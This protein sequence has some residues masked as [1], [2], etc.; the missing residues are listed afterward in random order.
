MGREGGREGGRDGGQRLPAGPPWASATLRRS[1]RPRA[2]HVAGARGMR[3]AWPKEGRDGV[4]ARAA[5]RPGQSCKLPSRKQGGGAPRLQRPGRSWGQRESSWVSDSAGW[6]A[7]QAGRLGTGRPR[8][9]QSGGGAAR[10]RMGWEP[11]P[12]AAEGAG[13]RAEPELR[14][15]GASEH[16]RAAPRAR[17]GSAVPG[18]GAGRGAGPRGSARP[19]SGPR[20]RSPAPARLRAALR[21]DWLSP[22]WAGSGQRGPRAA[23]QRE[24]A[25]GGFRVQ[26]GA[27]RRVVA[28]RGGEA[29]ETDHWG[30]SSAPPARRSSINGLLQWAPPRPVSQDRDSSP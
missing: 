4:R 1:E 18:P 21:A 27:W 14:H 3:A 5:A 26:P 17:G 22:C 6:G 11:R 24:R 12:Q 13:A 2:G 8:C 19:G 30:L 9:W 16:L 7:P 15:P 29:W 23:S 20:G 10:L 25:T 28:V